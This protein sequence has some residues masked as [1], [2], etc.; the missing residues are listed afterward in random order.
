MFVNNHEWGSFS[1]RICSRHCNFNNKVKSHLANIKFFLWSFCSY[2]ILLEKVTYGYQAVT[3]AR[4]G[5][6]HALSDVSIYLL[7]EI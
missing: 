4:P 5:V 2:E 6:G 1:L 7:T 3:E